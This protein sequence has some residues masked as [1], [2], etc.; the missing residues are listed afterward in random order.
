M[1]YQTDF[2]NPNNVMYNPYNMTNPPQYTYPVNNMSNPQQRYKGLSG[3]IINN[4]NEITPYEI[5]MDGSMVL[6]PL[7]DKSQIVGKIWQADGTIQTIHFVKESPI[8]EDVSETNDEIPQWIDDKMQ[9][10]QD[11]INNLKKDME[12]KLQPKQTTTRK[13]TTT[14]N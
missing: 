8:E 7:V 13:R 2:N 5:P 11:Q 12:K 4:E 9:D 3:R 10:L 6:F 14:S 1:P